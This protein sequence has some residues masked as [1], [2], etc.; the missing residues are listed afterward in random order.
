MSSP[1]VAGAAA[2]YL[3]TNNGAAPRNRAHGDREPAH[4]GRRG[5]S[6]RSVNNHLLCTPS[7][8][9]VAARSLRP[10]MPASRP[11]A[12]ALTCS[13]NSTST[14]VD[15]GLL[16]D[17]RR[18]RQRHRLADEPHVRLGRHPNRD[19]HRHRAGRHRQR[20]A[21]S[22]RDNAPS[23]GFT[24]SASGFKVKG[25]QHAQLDWSGAASGTFN[26][27]RN[28]DSRWDRVR[29]ERQRG[30]HHREQ[31]R[32]HVR[33]PPLQYERR[34]LEQQHRRLLAAP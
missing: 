8:S 28:G 13:F 19:A 27:I 21:A 10:L 11:S 16:V 5:R 1:H 33:L 26:I 24:L 29:L 14:G 30:P 17:V 2:L 18:R 32:R 6:P 3:Q 12:T 23:G 25:A 22:H 4:A 15:I 34:L 9:V 7:G 20:V 31:G